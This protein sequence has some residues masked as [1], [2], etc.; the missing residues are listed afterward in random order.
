MSWMQENTYYVVEN[1]SAVKIKRGLADAMAKG[2]LVCVI[3]H[4]VDVCMYIYCCQ[5]CE[6]DVF[7]NQYQSQFRALKMCIGL[8]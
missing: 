8:A 2:T 7:K 5:F 1:S 4:V 3:P 6:H